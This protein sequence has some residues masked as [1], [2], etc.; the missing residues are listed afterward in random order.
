MKLETAQALIRQAAAINGHVPVYG[1]T[2]TYEV[3]AIQGVDA[4]GAWITSCPTATL[5]AYVRIPRRGQAAVIA[6][7]KTIIAREAEIRAERAARL[8]AALDR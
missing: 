4:Q 6:R 8:Q 7:A 1:E 2:A 3:R 5:R